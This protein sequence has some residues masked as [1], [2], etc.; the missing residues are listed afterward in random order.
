M[1]SEWNQSLK[2]KIN[3]QVEGEIFMKQWIKKNLIKTNQNEQNQLLICALWKLT[4]CFP[5]IMTILNEEKK[6]SS[7]SDWII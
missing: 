7:E 3:A 1:K 6:T 4:F 5:I 2:L